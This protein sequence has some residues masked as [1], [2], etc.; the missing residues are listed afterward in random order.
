[1]TDFSFEAA[2]IRETI[3]AEAAIIRAALTAPH[4]LLKAE[5]KDMGEYWSCFYHDIYGTG[6]TPQDA[7]RDFDSIWAEQLA[8]QRR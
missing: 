6:E 1:M 8:N 4:I 7:A 3:C 5:V 2:I